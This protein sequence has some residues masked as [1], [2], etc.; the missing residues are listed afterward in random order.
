MMLRLAVS[1]SLS[2]ALGCG[3]RSERETMMDPLSGVTAQELYD[4]GLGHAARGD[5]IRAEQYFVA[6]IEKGQPESQVL[7]MLVRICVASSRHSAALAHA[8]PYLRANPGE[9][10]LRL[11]V[12]S[13]HLGLGEVDNARQ[14]L[15][16][17][18]LEAPDDPAAYYMLGMLYRE[19]LTDEATARPLMER[20]LELA[21]SG[22]H[23]DEVRAA[24]AAGPMHRVITPIVPTSGDASV[25]APVDAS[26][27][28]SPEA[29][30]AENEGES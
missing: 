17:V 2:L 27:D 13:L 28:V 21:P 19:E 26:V 4:G 6:A 10:R 15:H 5:L 14:D 23:A 22:G 25:D 1:L 9:W 12:A 11:L 30:S 20:Y 7:P 29:G 8:E 3:A 18:L 24:L 16:R